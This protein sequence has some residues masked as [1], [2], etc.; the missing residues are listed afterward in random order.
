MTLNTLS[1]FLCAIPGSNFE[2]ILRLVP[3]AGYLKRH[4]FP[5]LYGVRRAVS[6]PHEKRTI[7][8]LERPEDVFDLDLFLAVLHHLL[9]FA[10]FAVLTGEL[11]L[12][13]APMSAD[14]VRRLA[15]LDSAYGALAVGILVVGFVRA[16]YAAK[17]WEYYSANPFFH[18]KLTT[19]ILIGLLSIWPTVQIIRWRRRLQSDS[20]AVPL[21]S[22]VQVMRR[23]LWAEILLFALMPIFAA[24]MARNTL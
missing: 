4:T 24:A 3:T 23:V 16:I 7:A 22:E 11:L 8:I 9:V 21:Q 12:A 1:Q 14:D 17:G 10:L 15:A 6:A 13:R 19:F 5:G 18:A 2:N 20:A